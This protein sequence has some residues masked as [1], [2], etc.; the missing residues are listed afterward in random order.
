MGTELIADY[1]CITGEAPLWHPGEGQLYWSD[2]PAGRM[3]R[4]DPQ[5]GRHEQFYQGEPVGSFTIQ[6]DGSLLLL[7]VRGSVRVWAGGTLVTLI[8]EI[9]DE[10]ETRFNDAIAD[11]M[12]RVFAGTMPARDRSSR[13]Y[14]LEA[15]GTPF[16]ML[17]DLGQA[18]GMGFSPDRR[19]LYL[20]DTRER[21]IYRFKYDPIRGDLTGRQVFAE[22]PDAEGEG[23]PDGLTVD[24]DG[25][26][27]SARWGGGCVVRYAPDGT[28][29]QRIVLPTLK[30]S[31]L[32]FGGESYQDLYITSAGGDNRV[33]NGP[34]AGALFRVCPGVTGMPEFRSRVGTAN[35]LAPGL[36]A[37]A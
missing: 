9:P 18:N 14:R 13:L 36:P 11:P 30:I 23:N 33:E 4:Y 3:Y 2:I 8:E 26:V 29:E 7:G 28:E 32:A 24:A 21:R 34:H 17:G 20:T 25:H 1:Q 31:S 12:G 35:P 16:Q 27:W 37:A 22:V 15:D 10:R 6:E 5:T 19:F